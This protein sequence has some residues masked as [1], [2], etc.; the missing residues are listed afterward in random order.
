MPTLL[1]AYIFRLLPRLLYLF[2][3]TRLVFFSFC[4]SF[5]SPQEE[6]HARAELE[7][8]RQEQRLRE[9]NR[10][11]REIAE[12]RRLRELKK[13]VLARTYTE[14]LCVRFLFFRFFKEDSRVFYQGNNVF[15]TLRSTLIGGLFTVLCGELTLLRRLLH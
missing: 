12:E 6:N 11:Q 7:R 10:R 4:I 14:T 5:L 15:E 3:A 8:R 13:K 9:R 2:G 1:S